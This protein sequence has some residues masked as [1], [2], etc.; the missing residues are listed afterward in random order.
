[1]RDATSSVVSGRSIFY[2]SSSG[3]LYVFDDGLPA[4]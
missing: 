3:G 2:I 4:P 1:V